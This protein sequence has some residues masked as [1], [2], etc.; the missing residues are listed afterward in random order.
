MEN[1]DC[2]IDHEQTSENND[3]LLRKCSICKTIKSHSNFVKSKNQKCGI[4]Y[5]CYNCKKRQN[6]K[7]TCNICFMDVPIR[8]KKRHFNKIWHEKLEK[9]INELK[10]QSH[11]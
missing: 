6:D 8:Y 4:G 10:E 11:P 5:I 7:F 2:Q 9:Y 3:S 1:K